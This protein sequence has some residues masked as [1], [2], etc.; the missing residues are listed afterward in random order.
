[1]V[2]AK[3]LDHVDRNLFGEKLK[4]FGLS[5]IITDL[6]TSFLHDRQQ[7]TAIDGYLSNW[8]VLRGGIPR[9]S[10]LRPLVNFI[11]IDNLKLD[12][13]THKYVDDT[14]LSEM[15]GK[16]QV[17]WMQSAVDELITWSKANAMNVNTWNTKEMV[18]GPLT[19]NPPTQIVIGDRTVDRVLQFTLLGVTVNEVLKWND[20]VV[21][22]K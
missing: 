16:S 21:S 5:E 14:T 18:I 10:W 15:L 12:M 19:R 1:V 13:L 7:R 3:A 8:A 22:R 4:S 17:S 6:I 11:L 20:H 9:E 2:F